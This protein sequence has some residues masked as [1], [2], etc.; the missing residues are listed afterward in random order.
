MGDA[1]DLFVGLV[2]RTAGG[3]EKRLPMSSSRTRR[4]CSKRTPQRPTTF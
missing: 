2:W 3:E 1:L 4:R